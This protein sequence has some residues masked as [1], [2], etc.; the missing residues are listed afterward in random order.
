MTE[1]KRLR[2]SVSNRQIA[3]VCGGLGE[4]FDL[5]PV[6]V[7]VLWIT[8][9]IVPGALLF[10][11]L[12]YVVA[13]LVIPE[14]SPGTAQIDGGAGDSW[15]SRRLRRS[16]ADARIA[17]VCGGIA[18]YFSV[19]PTAVRVLWVLVSIFPG[20]VICGVIAYVVAWI[21]MPAAP[22]PLPAAPVTPPAADGV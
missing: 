14:V 4:F 12:A 8:L 9:T 15:R 3:G 11:I 2:R 13:W 10:G 22:L 20:A 6:L 5:D 7:R 17:G 18:E 19:D 1:A 21:V 16:A